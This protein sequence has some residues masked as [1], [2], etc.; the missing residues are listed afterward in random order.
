[1][2]GFLVDDGT[3][4]TPARPRRALTD[5][6]SP[7][8]LQPTYEQTA[9]A[10]ASATGEHLVIQAGAGTG[11]TTTLTQLAASTSRRGLYIAFNR[12]IA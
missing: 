11:K 7:T 9:A 6:R 4:T 10:D 5:R 12:S 3:L 1:M 8:M 2:R